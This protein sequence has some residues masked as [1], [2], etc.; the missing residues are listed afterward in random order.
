[1]K[2]YCPQRPV[3]LLNPFQ[4]LLYVAIEKNNQHSDLFCL[5]GEADIRQ[6]GFAGCKLDAGDPMFEESK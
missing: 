1:M 2:E 5:H 6:R 3:M 4:K